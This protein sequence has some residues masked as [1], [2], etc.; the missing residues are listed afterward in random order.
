MRHLL[1]AL[2]A[3]ILLAAA[4]APVRAQDAAN[5]KTLYNTRYGAPNMGC[6]SCHGVQGDVLVNINNIRNGVNKPAVIQSAIDNNTGGMGFLKPFLNATQVADIAAYLG[7]PS[8]SGVGVPSATIAPATLAFAPVNVGSSS[9]PQTVTLTNTGTGPLSLSSLGSSNAAFRI[10]GGTCAAGA[11]VAQGANCTITMVFRPGVA[12]AVSGT[13]TVSHN[14]GSGTSSVSMSGTGVV[15]APVASVTPTRL[16]YTQVVGATSPAQ[17]ATLS[18]TG[19]AALVLSSVAVTGAQAAEFALE[20]GGC[21]V[22]TSVAPGAS[23]T[24]NLSFTPVATGSRSAVL[25]MAHN[26]GSGSSTVSLAGT[27]T[28]VP[29]PVISL[30]LASVAF[31]SQAL[32]TRSSARR[33][34]VSNTGSQTLVLSALTLAGKNAADFGQ[35]GTCTVG[36]S[37]VPGASCALDLSF[38]P[39]ALG[40]RGATL[41]IASNA[42]NGNAVLSLSGNGV[43]APAPQVTLTPAAI[44]FGNQTVGAPDASR[45]VTLAN[46]G[47]APLSLNAISAS[48]A[49]FSASHQCGTS[50]APAQSCA[51]DVR[52]APASVAA[53]SGVLAVASD[54]AGSPHQVALSGQGVA[55]PLPVLVWGGTVD[56]NFADTAV[57]RS[58]WPNTWTLVNQGPGTVT[59]EAVAV[60]GANADE[61]VVGGTCT[62]G[63]ALAAGAECAVSVSF[64]PSQVGT[65]SAQLDVRS[66]GSNPAPVV[67]G[68][69]AV[70]VVQSTLALSV[71]SLDFPT[72]RA[73][74]SPAPMAV[75]LS[76]TGNASL[77]VGAVDFSVDVLSARPSAQGGCGAWPLVLAAGSQCSVDVLLD[78]ST[79]G[80][81]TATMT[82]AS[83]AAVTPAPVPVHATV[84][85]ADDDDSGPGNAGAGGCS[86][87]RPDDPADPSLPLMSVAAVMVLLL[88]RRRD[89]STTGVHE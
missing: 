44:D 18:N 42:S 60:Q 67:L 68:G 6:Y 38:A 33:V 40:A 63:S 17:S 23:C 35:T 34:S 12:G 48:G 22:G 54:A 75:T 1:P 86:I 46:S 2:F 32:G 43:P 78:A 61:F 27:G 77:M 36:Q 5:G 81:I 50:L 8:L 11:S 89:P 71:T 59:L 72:V 39:Q 47:S 4:S 53:Y 64:V 51:V 30:N 87:G 79:A 41:T 3:A 26:A 10:S 83:N 16:S 62:P 58:S 56:G 84:A 37:L 88:R 13:L 25:T 21:G 85:A 69:T 76:N 82:V 55:R 66:D 15:L 24:V 80:V 9:A 52:F 70:A 73:G 20:P 19:N 57:G 65:R 31:G 49:G 28:S 14:A 29:Q 74:A 45:T 7:N